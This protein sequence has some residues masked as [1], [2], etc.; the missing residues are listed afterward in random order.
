MTLPL[1]VVC[2]Y[3]YALY[4]C[5][6]KIH[7]SQFVKY[8]RN[9]KV[10]EVFSVPF[11][12]FFFVFSCLGGGGYLLTVSLSSGCSFVIVRVGKGR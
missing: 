11:R 3:L 6:Y 1:T 5:P 12:F 2:L 7:S 8:D 4:A 10:P 9:R